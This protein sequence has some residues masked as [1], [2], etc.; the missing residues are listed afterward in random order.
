M[1]IRDWLAVIVIVFIVLILLDGFRRKW[2]ERKNRT[3][4]Y[5]RTHE[6]VSKSSAE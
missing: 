6:K 1:N 4:F 2:L 3:G 5:S